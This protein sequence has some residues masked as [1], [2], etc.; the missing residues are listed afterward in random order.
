MADVKDPTNFKKLGETWL[1]IISFE[2]AVFFSNFT[3][4]VLPSKFGVVY[5]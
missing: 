1:E 3:Y 4:Q 5:L 2:A